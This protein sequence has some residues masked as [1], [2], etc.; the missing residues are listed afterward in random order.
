MLAV[1]ILS[2]SEMCLHS[3]YYVVLYELSLTKV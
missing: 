3:G 2:L 1:H